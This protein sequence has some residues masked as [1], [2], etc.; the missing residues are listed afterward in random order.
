MDETAGEDGV[1]SRE[2]IAV[3]DVAK[4]YAHRVANEELSLVI[5]VGE[6]FGL[7]GANGGGKTTTLRILAGILKPDR[8]HGQVL[9]FDLLRA[10]SEIRARR[11]HVATVFP[12]CGPIGFRESALSS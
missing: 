2:V 8:G 4:R 7:V 11:L 9:G 12:V 10:A 5:R 3:E 6:V 1:V